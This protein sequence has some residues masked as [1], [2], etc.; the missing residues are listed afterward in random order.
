VRVLMAEYRKSLRE[1][2]RM[3]CVVDSKI[4]KSLDN[5]KK[6]TIQD[7]EDKK[8][9][10]SMISDLEYALEW[11][12]SGRNP[13][14]RRGIDKNGV[15]LTNPAI[16]EI[17]PVAPTYKTVKKEISGW[18]KEIIEDALCI[19]TEREKDVFFMIKVEGITFEYTA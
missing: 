19:L 3:K 18:E 7:E 5:K 2:M 12:Q 1:A 15:Y 13:D 11:M 8:V 9:I 10:A 4:Q 16:L 6:P 17:L 14:A